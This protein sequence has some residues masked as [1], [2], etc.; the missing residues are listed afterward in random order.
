MDDLEVSIHSLNLKV[1][2]TVQAN[3]SALF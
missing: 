2:K 3:L 1:W